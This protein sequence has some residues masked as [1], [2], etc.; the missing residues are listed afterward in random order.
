[1]LLALALTALAALPLPAQ[2]PAR[3]P[4]PAEP[5][6]RIEPHRAERPPPPN[7]AGPRLRALLRRSRGPYRV[8][9]IDVDRRAL[10]ARGVEA[11]AEVGP[12]SVLRVEGDA[13]AAVARAARSLELPAPHRPLLDLS[14]VAIGAEATDRGASFAAPHRGQGVLIGAYD[15]GIDLSHPDFRTLDGRLRVLGT[16]DQDR[17][18]SCAPAELSDGGCAFTDAT[19]HG[20]HVLSIAAGASPR[21][22]G[23]APEAD[24]LVARSTLYDG[25]VEALAWLRDRA[26]AAGRPL[27]INVSLGGHLGAHDGTSPE[28]LAIDALD[29]LVVVA[30]GNEGLDTVHA[31]TTLVPGAPVDLALDLPPDGQ[32]QHAIIDLWGAPTSSIT[33]ELIAVEGGAVVYASG[34][35]GLGSAGATQTIRVRGAEL[36]T[37][38]LDAEAALN[39]RNGRPHLTLE[40]ALPG[41]TAEQALALRLRG[42]GEVH[43]WIDTLATVAAPP[44]FSG[45]ARLGTA[46]EIVGDTALTLSD[47]AAAKT[48]VAVSSWITRTRIEDL[49]V[50]FDDPLFGISAFSSFG[51]SLDPARTGPKPDLAAPGAHVVAAARR[52]PPVGGLH[53]GTMYRALSGTSMAVPHVAGA[54]A[55]LLEIAPQLDKERLRGL[56]L[57]H[58]RPQG[59]DPRFGRGALDIEASAHAALGDAGCGCSDAGARH[60]LPLLLLLAAALWVYALRRGGPT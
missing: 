42:S 54:A 27:V 19:G 40:L 3:G 6:R 35:V 44:S 8:L 17:D 24:L 36:G 55:V 38:D 26:R 30:A 13:L 53:V 59:S 20:T 39:P 43:A 47:L 50:S 21:F 9:A 18:Q 34:A 56:L 23:I 33:A 46:H 22:R 5:P 29:A 48:A 16:L 58:A 51:P 11:L 14:R 57:D 60:D 37:V 32:E 15:S 28:C 7:N 12:V 10:P 31:R 52:S 45:L 4:G 1:M 41:W 49:S 2:G 25:F